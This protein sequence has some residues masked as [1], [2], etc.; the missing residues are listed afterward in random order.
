M[1]K[2]APSREM[3]TTAGALYKIAANKLERGHACTESIAL[4][5]L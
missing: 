5:T 2:S 1:A 3:D 4:Q